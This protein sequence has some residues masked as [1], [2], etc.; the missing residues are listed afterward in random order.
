MLHTIAVSCYGAVVVVIVRYL[1]LQLSMQSVPI[2]SSN[3]TR[4]RTI[5]DTTLCGNFQ[6][7]FGRSVVFCGFLHRHDINDT[8]TLT[9]FNLLLN[10]S[11]YNVGNL[12]FT[13]AI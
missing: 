13:G 1:D 3:P 11:L 10:Y 2:V 12:K 6:V 7:P 4:V 5:L 8:I 9:L